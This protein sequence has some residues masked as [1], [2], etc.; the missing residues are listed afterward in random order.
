MT[1]FA[2][3][4]FHGF[5]VSR[6]NAVSIATGYGI[7]GGV[8]VRFPIGARIFSFPRRPDQFWGPPSLLS[9]GYPRV[10]S[11]GREADHSLPTSTEVRNTGIYTS[12]PPYVFMV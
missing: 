1:E 7:D 6:D 8:R 4:V 10:L 2:F 5:L 11:P 3:T 9:N 12:T